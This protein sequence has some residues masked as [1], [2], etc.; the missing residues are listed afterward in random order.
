MNAPFGNRFSAGALSLALAGLLAGCQTMQQESADSGLPQPPG[1]PEAF[2]GAIGPAD[3]SGGSAWELGWAL[4]H[5]P[6]L[7]A[8]RAEALGGDPGMELAA[9][10]L[11]EARALLAGR[12]AL[13]RP[14]LD[15]DASVRVMG[16]TAEQTALARLGVPSRER[17]DRYQ[18]SLTA[19]YELDLWGRLKLQRDAADRR[20]AAAESD[21]EEA[22]QLVSAEVARAWYSW[23]GLRDEKRLLERMLLNRA[24]GVRL[25]TADLEAGRRPEMELVQAR[26]E[27][28]TLEAEIAGLASEAEAAALAL[29]RL[30]GRA[31]RTLLDTQGMTAALQAPKLPAL[32]EQPAAMLRRRPDVA[33]AEAQ[34]RA[35]LAEAEVAL[36]NRKPDLRLQAT[37]GL[38][39]LDL[40]DLLNRPSQFWQFGPAL[41]LP[42]FSG[43]RLKAE[44]V[45]A[46]A[47]A[48]AATAR[49]RQ[50]VLDAVRAIE[51]DV[52]ELAHLDVRAKAVAR[53]HAQA[54][55]LLQLARVR[56]NA[57]FGGY[58]EVVD[59]ERSLLAQERSAAGLETRKLVVTA[60]LVRNLGTRRHSAPDY[61]SAENAMADARAP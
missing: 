6:V 16:E 55:D 40:G 11:A 42:L 21:L 39:S 36:L 19:R 3:R 52:A 29:E 53:A 41:H 7:D 45:A 33:S 28:A 35:A 23:L 2:R 25:R 34:W 32:E 37:A 59:A 51:L 46:E 15:L 54:L 18:T 47:R 44:Q 20:V 22:R 24:D 27:I 13:E 12:G 56:H 43:G 8:L 17:G 31:A 4:F 10:R 5:D 48:Q 14:T 50:V 38:D 26:L 58:L 1:M 57:G 30:C 49:Y 9:A 61:D 60:S